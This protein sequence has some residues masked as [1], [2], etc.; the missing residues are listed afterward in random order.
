MTAQLK[1][2]IE[3]ALEAAGDM[4]HRIP[5]VEHILLGLAREKD[6]LASK[7]L[8]ESGVEEVRLRSEIERLL[9]N[10]D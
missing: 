4:N 9:R 3:L 5:G 1:R 2:A 6:G 10:A 8:R 7:V